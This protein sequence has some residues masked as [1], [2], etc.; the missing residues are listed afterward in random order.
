MRVKW[1]EGGVCAPID[2]LASG[3]NSGIKPRKLDSSLVFSK[4]D[5]RV[6]A[7]FTRN[8]AKAW[9]VLFA[10]KN[11]NRK[12]HRAILA[13]SGN[14]NCF[15]GT[16][17]EKAMHK[18]LALTAKALGIEPEEILPASTGIIGEPFPTEKLCGGIKRLVVSLSPEGSAKA[19]EGILTTDTRIKEIACE[20]QLGGKKVRVGAIAK[21][22]G[23]MNPN[24]ATMLCFL[25]TDAAISKTLL[26]SALQDAVKESFN[27]I[28]VDTDMSTNDT[29]YFLANGAAGNSEIKKKDK[30][31]K[32][33]A[34]AITEICKRL[35]RELIKDGE[36]VKRI[37]DIFIHGAKTA[38]DADKIAKQLG[39]SMLFKTMIAGADPNWGR[40]VASLGSTRIPFD[41]SKLDISFQGTK[42][43]SNGSPINGIRPRLRKKLKVSEVRVDVDLKL[44]KGSAWFLTCDL[45]T[46]YVRINAWYTT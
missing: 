3:L 38:A 20:F 8:T 34:E 28:S 25:S 4:R 18:T 23:M 39:Y 29:V 12:S 42:I 24:M 27:R 26:K 19:A 32:L 45:T 5:A 9:P 17:G 15:N 35:A 14:A 10:Q 2:F 13:N 43:L 22:S 31:Y 6:A 46:A 30:D 44:G 11:I 7:V 37:V 33:F 41:S 16:Q 21:G 36:G 1:I 40:V